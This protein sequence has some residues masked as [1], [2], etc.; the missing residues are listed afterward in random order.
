VV[1]SFDHQAFHGRGNAQFLS[2]TSFRPNGQLFGGKV[3]WLEKVIKAFENL[4]GEDL[5]NNI[6]LGV[7][8]STD[9]PPRVALEEVQGVFGCCFQHIRHFSLKHL[10]PL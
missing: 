7:V 4:E 6:L 1:S 10:E 2:K 8:E 5:R 3:V 9:R